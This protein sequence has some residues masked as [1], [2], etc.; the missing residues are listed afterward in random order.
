MDVGAP[1][2]EWQVMRRG[3]ANAHDCEQFR[4]QEEIILKYSNLTEADRRA[5]EKKLKLNRLIEAETDSGIAAEASSAERRAAGRCVPDDDPRL[6][7][8]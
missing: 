7:P 8:K 6:K 4:A 2:D 3:F 1:V 5:L